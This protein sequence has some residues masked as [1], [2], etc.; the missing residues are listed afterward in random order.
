MY[1]F[2]SQMALLGVEPSSHGFFLA[3]VCGPLSC[4]MALDP[5]NATRLFAASGR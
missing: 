3:F 5:A 1:Q 4:R 2:C